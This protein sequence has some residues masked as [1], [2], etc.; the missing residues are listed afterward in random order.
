MVSSYARDRHSSVLDS[1]LRAIDSGELQGLSK[2]RAVQEVQAD[3]L[4]TRCSQ[5][6]I[7]TKGILVSLKN[8]K[9][10]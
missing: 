1:K 3:E 8:E 10:G 6:E 9:Y 2:D 7:A 4:A 5:E